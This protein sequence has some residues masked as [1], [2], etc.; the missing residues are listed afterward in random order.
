MFEPGAKPTGPI[1]KK[2]GFSSNRIFSAHVLQKY[3]V[4]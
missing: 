3:K 4:L 2:F 1:A